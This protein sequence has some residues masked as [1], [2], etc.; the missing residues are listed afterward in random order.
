MNAFESGNRRSELPETFHS[1]FLGASLRASLIDDRRLFNGVWQR[2]APD[3]WKVPEDARVVT[4]QTVNGGQRVDICLLDGDPVRRVV[5][6]E[7][8]TKRASA[9]FGQ[10]ENYLAGLKKTFPG[11]RMA[12]AYLTP[13]NE[14]RGGE[15]AERLRTV[16]VF[17]EFESNCGAGQ[18]KHVSWL[19]VADIDWDGGIL[20]NEHRA[21]VREK[22]ASET[23][24]KLAVSRNRQFDAF[25]GQDATDRFREAL[26]DKGVELTEAGAVLDLD[27]FLDDAGY[28][29]RAYELLIEAS[30]DVSGREKKNEFPTDLQDD[31]CRSDP[32]GEIHEALFEL[33]R[34][35]KHVWLRG[36]A[37]YGLMVALPKRSS[38]V[39]LVR[40]LGFDRLAT[41]QPR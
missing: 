18:H 19:D 29:A 40:S 12:M 5:G 33:T 38:G 41:G 20:W 10:L 21:F 36:T 13:F 27:V 37:D 1:E 39:S 22:M 14:E 35:H 23:S 34:R 6:V 3:H 4:E 30:A 7:V 32:F 2:C 11:A 17:K 25:F 28:L 15:G 16:Q 8:K 26:M 24:R 9:E 31:F